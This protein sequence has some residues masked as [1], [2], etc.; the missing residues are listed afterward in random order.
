[1][2]FSIGILSLTVI[3]VEGASKVELLECSTGLLDMI[4]HQTV[5][6]LL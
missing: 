2:A 6:M 4:L 1:M 5:S 3:A